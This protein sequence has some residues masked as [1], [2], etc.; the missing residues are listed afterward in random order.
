MPAQ[1]R[2]WG[3]QNYRLR[4][5]EQGLPVL[6][7]N[8]LGTDL[9]MWD[10]VL[11]QLPDLRAIGL[12]KRGH[13]LSATDHAEFGLD[14]LVGDALAVLDHLGLARVMVAGCSVGGIIA[15]ALA[16]A[17]PDRVAGCF[18]SNTAMKVGTPDSWQARIDAVQA[19]GMASLAGPVIERWFGAAFRA[20]SDCAPWRVMLERA[21]PAGYIGICRVLA[22]ADLRAASPAIRCPVL[23]IAGSEDAATPTDLVRQT[24]AAIPGADCVEIEGA[25]H[26]PAIDAPLETARLLARFHRSLT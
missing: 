9:R 14:D 18:L 23:M 20:S 21:D 2:P 3:H 5:P 4:G 16:L 10:A 15:Q 11:D 13:G 6:F 24:A 17:A 1:I 8:S 19:G 25:G 7:L 12:D 22:R 26:I